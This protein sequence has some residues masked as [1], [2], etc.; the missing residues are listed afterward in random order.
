MPAITGV[1]AREVLDSRGMP[2]VEVKV[3]TN[4][5]LTG[6]IPPE[7]WASTG[8]AEALELRDGDPQRYDGRGV[9]KAVQHVQQIIAPAVI[10]M[11]PR[12]QREVD[13][14]LKKLDGT[15][16]K[17]KLGANAILG[18]SLAA[19]HAGA[20]VEQIPLF[21]HIADINQKTF[22]MIDLSATL[23]IPAVSRPGF[24][25]FLQRG[26][27][28]S[29]PMPMVNLI[30]GGLHAGGQL[31]FQ[32]F[33]MM[34][35]GASSYAE[36]L[37]WTV[38]VFRRLGELLK[39]A[40]YESALVADEGGYGP[41][42]KSPRE[43]CTLIVSAIEA[44][45]LQPREQV[46]LALDVASS[47][48]YDGQHYL[49]SGADTAKLTS[50]QMVDYLADL[51]AAFPIVSIEDGLA[52]EDWSGWYELTRR[53]SRKVWLVGDDLFATNHDRLLRGLEQSVANSVLIKVNQI[54][55]LSETLQT[56]A[57]ARRAG[58]A[59]IVSARSG[60]TED[61]TIAD[62]AVGSNAG[63]IKIGSITRSERLAKYNQLLRLAP[64]IPP[65]KL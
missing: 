55:T 58:Y 39:Q 13:D 9:L 41:K 2:T 61:T 14:R 6:L 32:D 63:Q 23:P 50:S 62:L 42:L 5:G 37:E 26:F 16:Q 15:P 56:M 59:T 60:E 57:L 11:D 43:A 40:G 49:L 53:L 36:G 45:G 35:V 12:Q 18:V 17:S 47:R 28:P 20:A 1:I 52:E 7:K 29:M 31:D 34:P 25:Q 44:A 22:E 27:E 30:S 48:F 51:V 21:R 64:L 19:A 24:P 65:R 3:H 10:G 33:L 38:R 54:G 46:A 4:Q 8:H